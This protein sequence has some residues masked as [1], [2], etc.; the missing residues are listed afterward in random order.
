MTR[1]ILPRSCVGK[2]KTP[3]A[4]SH[5]HDQRFD[6]RLH[7]RLHL[8]RSLALGLLNTLHFA[9]MSSDIDIRQDSPD[10]VEQSIASRPGRTPYRYT[11]EYLTDPKN[12][13]DL[14]YRTQELTDEAFNDLIDDVGIR[15][16][17]LVLRTKALSGDVRA[18]Q[19]YDAI[20]NR[21]RIKRK[22]LPQNER[23]V[24]SA[25]FIQSERDS[26]E[27]HD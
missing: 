19:L 27:T 20:T 24:S 17:R 2:E 18:L 3:K 16:A 13:A 26:P 12:I 9:L 23:N 6:L 25:P 14:L 10:T 15:A 11:L 22:E 21:D 1:F 5:A 8:R 4:S 7:R